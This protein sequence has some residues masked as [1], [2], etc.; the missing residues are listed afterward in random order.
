MFRSERSRFVTL[1]MQY[2]SVGSGIGKNRIKGKEDSY[3]HYAGTDS[4]L[5]EE[6]YKTYP[7][8]HMLPS[9]AGAVVI[10]YHLPGVSDLFLTQ[11]IAVGIFN[12]TI[13][14]WNSSLIQD[15]NRNFSLPNEKIRVIVRKDKSGTTEI[16]TS[17]LASFSSQWNSTYGVFARSSHWSEDVVYLKGQ[18][19]RGVSGLILSLPY[20]ISYLSISD[21][22]EANLKYAELRNKDGEWVD[23]R[24][25]NVQS[26]M[27]NFS[28]DMDERLTISLSNA[29]GK[30]S[31]PIAG[32]TYLIVRMKGLKDC[33]PAVELWRYIEWFTTNNAAHRECINKHMTPLNR[34]VAALVKKIVLDKM[35]CGEGNAV[36]EL[37]ADQKNS[38]YLS[39]QVWRI[40]AIVSGVVVGFLILLLM[41]YIIVQQYQLSR[42]L[43]RNDWFISNEKITL[44]GN[45][46][47]ASSLGSTYSAPH[48]TGVNNVKTLKLAFL[49]T[50][51]ICLRSST[52]KDVKELK[53]SA[54]R[55]LMWLK[56]N[57]QNNNIQKF[58]GVCHLGERVWFVSEY[59][60]KGSL[61]D[62]LLDE[63]YNLNDNFK[64]SMSIDIANGMA[65]LHSLDIIHLH[66]S[67]HCC[68]IDAKWSVKISDWEWITFHGKQVSHNQVSPLQ[69][70]LSEEVLEKR[71]FWLSPERLLHKSTTPTKQNDIYSFAIILIEIFTRDE[72]YQELDQTPQKILELIIHENLRPKINPNWNKKLVSI[73]CSS[74][75][76]NPEARPPF[77][78]IK[79][80]L[81][82]AAPSRK[83]V[84]DCMMEAVDNYLKELE[85][86]VEERTEELAKVMEQQ[87]SLLHEILPP[88]VA[89]KLSCGQSVPPEYYDSVTI[90]FSDIVGFTEISSSSTP[91]QVIT[92]LNELYSRFDKIIG[93]F[94]AYKVETIGDAY[95]VISGLP[96]R[97]CDT[98]VVEIARLSVEL[99]ESAMTMQLPHRKEEH[100]ALRVGIHTGP[101]M[102]GIVGLK[103][104]RYC[105][106]GDTV[107]VAS[108]ME[109]TSEPGKIQMSPTSAESLKAFKLDNLMIIPRGTLE[110]KGKGQMETF[111]LTK[112]KA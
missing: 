7:D 83:S 49:D 50:Q 37:V 86:R 36:S 109:S 46:L 72:P 43:S 8:L 3:V 89:D 40:P 42:A 5:T 4:L 23:A 19:N 106:F 16:F 91:M 32:Y 53:K 38:E 11:E 98:H 33:D 51:M 54:C 99:L 94:D 6:D 104:P 44:T 68:Y 96:K 34:E 110:I 81:T 85:Q 73:L 1:N 10:V 84:L 45:T 63:K 74:W 28:K 88:D 30:S 111:W 56:L 107:N 55:Q 12:G 112:R 78:R 97:N 47:E 101:V 13:K 15:Y 39:L 87:R 17:G 76:A 24:Y 66:L 92:L 64:Y 102:A 77:R 26:A 95:M 9:V 60:S 25:Q 22:K 48:S 27:T 41:S 57:V 65:Y 31:Y 80:E 105:L 108:R 29:G 90:Y 69:E 35:F 70:E 79:K 61:S 75:D 93:S 62:V 59:C 18:G 21:A 52:L 100:L 103:M 14:N 2:E 67:S 71:K 82:G 20:T 58:F